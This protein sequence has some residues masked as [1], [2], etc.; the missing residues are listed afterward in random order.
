MAKLFA[1]ETA[2]RIADRAVQVLGGRGYSVDSPAARHFRELRVDRIWE[3][4]SEIQRADHLGRAVQA[5][6]GAL[7]R[8]GVNDPRV[9]G[10][11]LALRHQQRV[12]LDLGQLGVTRGEHG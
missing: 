12:D 1:S 2:G 6:R 10:D 3:G 7:S 11:R 8:L 4:T 5:R 9:E